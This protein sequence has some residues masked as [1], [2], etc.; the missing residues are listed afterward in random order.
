MRGVSSIPEKGGTGVTYI[1]YLNQFNRWLESNALPVNAQLMFFRLLNVFNRAGWPETVQ[2]DT[3]RLMRMIDSLDRRTAYRARDKLAE[4]GLISFQKGGK[5]SPSRFRLGNIECIK[6]TENGT[7]NGTKSGTANGT[8]NGTGNG[9][10]IKTKNKTKTKNISS[11]PPSGGEGGS[12]GF[13]P[14]D[15]AYQAAVYLDEQIRAR[16]P[17]Q[18]PARE[19]QLQAWA[20]EFDRC[21]RLDGRSWEE[22]RRVLEFSQRDSFWQ[23]NI[24]SGGKFREKYLQLLAK[25]GASPPEQ[26]HTKSYD[27]DE[28]MKYSTLDLLDEL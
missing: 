5:G 2:V 16:Y 3:L 27:I 13:A 8:G 21:H 4:A 15:E 17:S 25:M 12:G 14:E 1:D 26:E 10:H 23:S 20:L 28:L 11:P 19:G 24:L 9:T 6:C 7:A 18:K 22:I